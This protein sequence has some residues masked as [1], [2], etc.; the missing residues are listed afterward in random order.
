LRVVK[1]LWR[2]EGKRRDAATFAKDET[3][4][5]NDRNPMKSQSMVLER[6]K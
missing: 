6:S 5:H 3:L 4:L 2:K 1:N